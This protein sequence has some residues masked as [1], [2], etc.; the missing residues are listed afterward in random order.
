MKKRAIA[1]LL[2]LTASVI[3]IS[4][5][6]TS[7]RKQPYANYIKR[8]KGYIKAEGNEYDLESNFSEQIAFQE[9][10]D[11]V[12]DKQIFMFG[13]YYMT[14]EV[15]LLA[16]KLFVLLH[17]NLGFKHML[18]NIDYEHQTDYDMWLETGNLQEGRFV[19]YF[20]KEAGKILRDYYKTLPVDE[21]FSIIC[22]KGIEEDEGDTFT[23][24]EK[25]M[26]A[27]K[28]TGSDAGYRLVVRS[29]KLKTYIRKRLERDPEEK[30]F[31]Y[32]SYKETTKYSD[33]SYFSYEY[34]TI[35]TY[36]NERNPYT[37]DSVA[38]SV[39]VV[40]SGRLYIGRN[41]VSV[42]PHDRFNNLPFLIFSIFGYDVDTYLLPLNHSR[43]GVAKGEIFDDVQEGG[44]Q[45]DSLAPDNNVSVSLVDIQY[46]YIGKRWDY[47]FYFQMV[48]PWER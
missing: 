18:L 8:V 16:S 15:N 20:T 5:L 14:K 31:I 34:E 36:L 38:S 33:L 45:I 13:E 37:K 30:L 25:Y 3:F 41:K 27:S 44:W 21:K 19:P 46:N 17:K 26:A 29:N 12:K 10:L 42:I 28:G 1:L 48:T 24:R 6:L 2:I 23:S 9:L 39:C 35:G 47:A 4:G 7:Q 40:R 11:E 43:M 32:I 22:M